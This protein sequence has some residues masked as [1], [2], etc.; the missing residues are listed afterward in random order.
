VIKNV[1]IHQQGTLPMVA[2][3]RELPAVG[4]ANLICTNIRTT[5]GK[6]PTFID[7]GDSWFVIPM[8][9][10]RFLEIPK[11]SMAALGLGPDELAE[12]VP[13]PKPEPVDEVPV[14]PDPDL[15]A[16]IRDL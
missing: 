15:L 6:R 5:D 4:D 8:V 2:D 12:P 11:E 10:V 7:A 14:E 9:T 3:V 1:V 16:R 13:E